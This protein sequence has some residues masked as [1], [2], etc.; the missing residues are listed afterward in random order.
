MSKEPIIGIYV[1]ANTVTRRRYIGSS[2]DIRRRILAHFAAL[3]RGKHENP[4]LQAS[5][6]KHGEE[7]FLAGVVEEYEASDLLEME[8]ELV[9]SHGYYNLN[10]TVG[11]PPS[12]RG[13]HNSAEH[14]EKCRQALLG[15]TFGPRPDDV[16]AKISAAQIGK[17]VSAEAREKMRAS[18]L[19]KKLSPWHRRAQ[20]EAAKGK[21]FS[22]SHR[23]NLSAA[24]R[25]TAARKAGS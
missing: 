22:A 18:H 17:A 25:R 21:V 5:W 2:I 7:A 11:R 16:K 9:S 24:R 12:R 10:Q 6:N 20:S 4:R 3:R 19:G 15:R 8:Q 14:R 13:Q 23:A 1:I